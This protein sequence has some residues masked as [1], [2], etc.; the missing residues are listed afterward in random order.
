MENSSSVFAIQQTLAVK[1]APV[2]SHSLQNKPAS[3]TER[4]RLIRECV[5]TQTE[6]A[7]ESLLCEEMSKNA[8]AI[9]L[10]LDSVL[11]SVARS[12][13]RAT[14]L[15]V[16]VGSL[17]M[18]LSY[19]PLPD[20]TKAA[21]TGHVIDRLMCRFNVRCPISCLRML[22]KNAARLRVVQLPVLIQVAHQV[23]HLTTSTHWR[24]QDAWTLVE[25][26]G[27]IVTAYSPSPEKPAHVDRRPGFRTRKSVQFH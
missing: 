2:V 12:A 5:A 23:H 14:I 21:I 6:C 13:D 11:D 1:P 19:L 20:G 4:C 9:S 16:F 3:V 26:N 22:H 7:L 10:L 17:P 15:R 25:T 27:V 18:T 24:L 8:K